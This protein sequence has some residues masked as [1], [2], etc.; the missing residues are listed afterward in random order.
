MIKITKNSIILHILQ[1][2]Y[3]SSFM[4]NNLNA[5]NKLMDHSNY[6]IRTCSRHHY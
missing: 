3:K 5:N 4:F 1:V 6:T 2:E